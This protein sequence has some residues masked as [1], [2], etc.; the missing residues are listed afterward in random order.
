M[1]EALL[2]G[3][4]TIDTPLPEE[5]QLELLDTKFNRLRGLAAA[6]LLVLVA[7]CGNSEAT[8][9]RPDPVAAEA[10]VDADATPIDPASLT[11]DYDPE[12]IQYPDPIP[13]PQGDKKITPKG[14]MLHWWGFESGGDMSV[15][16]QK[17]MNNRACGDT[18]C[19]AQ[20]T[21]AKDG[22]IYRMMA[23]PLEMAF[24]AR[25]ANPTTIAIEIEG[26]PGDFEL[27]G[28]VTNK[29]VLI[30]VVSLSAELVEDFRLPIEGEVICEDVRGI[31]GH[32]E[33]NGRCGN[34]PDKKPDVGDAFTQAVIAGVYSMQ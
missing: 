6:G 26:G 29:A 14:I 1:S 20:Y 22:T 33:L 10:G 19:S 7:A 12:I 30:S 8:T 9:S 25:G 5:N 27:S 18:G 32:S 2:N 28:N 17:I 15:F 16:R 21:V 4:T 23:S 31:H 3:V 13:N 34:P 11:Y 24:Q